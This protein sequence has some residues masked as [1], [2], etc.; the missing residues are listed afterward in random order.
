MSSRQMPFVAAKDIRASLYGTS[1]SAVMSLL[2]CLTRSVIA[3]LSLKLL[4][5]ATFFISLRRRKR[6]LLS[7]TEHCLQEV[8]SKTVLPAHGK[9]NGDDQG[10]ALGI[11][12][13]GSTD[14]AKTIP[15]CML[16]PA[17]RE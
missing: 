8:V 9:V 2:C 4:K 3:K 1:F 6:L 11:D 10:N 16:I 5:T 7:A 14:Q 15:E 13:V 17:S 12:V